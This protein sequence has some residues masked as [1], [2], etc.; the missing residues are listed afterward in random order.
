[1]PPPPANYQPAPTGRN[2]NNNLWYSFDYGAIHYLMMSTGNGLK[3]IVHLFLIF[4]EHDFLPGSV[5]YDFIV[6][7]LSTVD[8]AVTPWVVYMGHR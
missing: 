2:N 7:D 3:Q 5:Q 6:N 8:R 4:S 1:M